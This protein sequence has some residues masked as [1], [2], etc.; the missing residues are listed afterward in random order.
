MRIIA[1][2]FGGRVLRAARKSSTRPTADRVKEAW[3]S[4]IQGDV[5]GS[6]ALDLFAGTGSLGLEAISRGASHVDLVD[7]DR[8][9][10][11]TIKTNV[12]ALGVQSRCKVIQQDAIRFARRL[13]ASAYD[14]AFADPP[15]R[16]EY[17]TRLLQIY[18]DTPFARV[19]GIEHRA[20]L[21]LT[22]H[23]TEVYGDTAITFLYAS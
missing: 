21:E 19:L 17:A 18:A 20:S 3:M 9:S 6:R 14:L 16:S 2:E 22:G 5:A 4:I 15:F 7:V 13:E 10:V 23:R 11:E 12:A 1:G 8:A